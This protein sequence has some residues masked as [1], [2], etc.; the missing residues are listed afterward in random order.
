MAGLSSKQQMQIFQT[1]LARLDQ[2]KNGPPDSFTDEEKDWYKKMEESTLEDRQ[3]GRIVNYDFP[4]D[5]D[6]ENGFY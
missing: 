3:A 1:M 2:G 4:N 6:W 5:Y